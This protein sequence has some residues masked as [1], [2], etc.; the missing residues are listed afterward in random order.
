M[1]PK[2][3]L[4]LTVKIVVIEASTNVDIATI[5]LQSLNK[6]RTDT[7]SKDPNNMLNELDEDDSD[8]EQEL[9]GGE[10]MDTLTYFYDVYKE[11]EQTV[12]KNTNAQDEDA[13]NQTGA[14]GE[15]KQ[16]KS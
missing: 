3:F 6:K 12:T 13:S 16:D 14:P 15:K 10:L 2:G 8:D 11:R 1:D 4:Y 9:G 5:T 7:A